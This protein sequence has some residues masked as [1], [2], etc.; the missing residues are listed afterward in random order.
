MSYETNTR[1][2]IVNSFLL[3]TLKFYLLHKKS[4]IGIQ[5]FFL[6][7]CVCVCVVVSKELA[8]NYYS[9]NLSILLYPHLKKLLFDIIH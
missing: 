7:M 5:R 3:N 1:S 2:S 9:V 4:V 8:N 6:S